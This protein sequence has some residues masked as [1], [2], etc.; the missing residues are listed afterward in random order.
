MKRNLF[1]KIFF[2]YL[3]IIC[4]S[5]LVL[6]IFI[7]DEMRKVMTGKIEGEL[8]TYVELI[9]LSSARAMSDQLRQIASISGSRVTLV[10]ARGRVFA[11]SDDGK[12]YRRA[13]P[14]RASGQHY[15]AHL[16]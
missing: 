14:G 5:F 6:N 15:F 7:K 12:I 2:S 10:D 3:V 9:D 16:R 13:S 4:F 1:L 11:D 8:L